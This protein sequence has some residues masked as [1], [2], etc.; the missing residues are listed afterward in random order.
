[1]YSVKRDCKPGS[2]LPQVWRVNRNRWKRYIYH[3]HMRWRPEAKRTAI[4][5]YNPQLKCSHIEMVQTLEAFWQIA[6]L[7]WELKPAARATSRRKISSEASSA[8]QPSMC[9][10]HCDIWSQWREGPGKKT[11]KNREGMQ[12]RKTLPIVISWETCTACCPEWSMWVRRTGFIW[13]WI[14]PEENA[15]NAHKRSSAWSQRTPLLADKAVPVLLSTGGQYH[16]LTATAPPEFFFF[17]FTGT[18]NTLPSVY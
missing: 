4:N 17:S 1:M 15:L 14:K 11:K 16:S 18:K 12:N 5:L 8:L 3:Q 7:L 9:L 6:V 10:K 2:S 13:R